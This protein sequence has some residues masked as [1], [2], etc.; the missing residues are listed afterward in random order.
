LSLNAVLANFPLFI[1][2]VINIFYKI[3]MIIA[4]F[5]ATKAIR[6]YIE[7]NSKNNNGNL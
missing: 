4:L 1:V 3:S 5:Y 6:L 7:K 2:E